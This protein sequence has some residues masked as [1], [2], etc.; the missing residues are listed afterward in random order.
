[1]HQLEISQLGPTARGQ[2]LVINIAKRANRISK[3]YSDSQRC[4]KVFES[5]L[6]ASGKFLQIVF[7]YYMYIQRCRYTTQKLCETTVANVANKQFKSLKASPSSLCSDIKQ[8]CKSFHN[9]LSTFPTS[10]RRKALCEAL[11]WLTTVQR[12]LRVYWNVM[13]LRIRCMK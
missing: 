3:L 9:V 11:Q 10:R 1:M 6:K 8:C 13:F 7:N 4:T 5:V 12:C 2:L